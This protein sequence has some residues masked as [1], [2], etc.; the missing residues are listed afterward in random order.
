MKNCA[1]MDW[2]G[3]GSGT[4]A[5]GWRPPQT[6]VA[7]TRLCY[8]RRLLFIVQIENKRRVACARME[9][10]GETQMIEDEGS[11]RTGQRADRGCASMEAGPGYHK[12]QTTQPQFR[13][14]WWPAES[15]RWQVGK[16][17]LRT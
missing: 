14:N 11:R 17:T 6:S 10:A 15:H 4:A 7:H 8:L 9:D 5:D 2:P 1:S 12:G 13:S 3:G 16:P